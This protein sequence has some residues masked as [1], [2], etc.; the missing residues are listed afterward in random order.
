M[1]ITNFNVKAVD[2][3]GQNHWVFLKVLTDEGID[4]VGEINPSA[5]RRD[6]LNALKILENRVMGQDP[7]QIEYLIMKLQPTLKGRAT[8]HALSAFEQCLWD[9]LG[10]CLNTPIYT[11]LGGKFR[12]SIPVYANITRAAKQGTAED[13]VN[14]ATKAVEAGHWAIKI[15]PF[16]KRFGTGSALIDHGLHCVHSVQEAI[17]SEIKVLLDCYGLFSLDE[18][19]QI[20]K[21]VSNINLYWL[22]EPLPDSDI[23]GYRQLKKETN[24]RIAGGER[25][26]LINGFWPLLNTNIMDVIMPDVT[27][28]GGISELKKIASIA[29]HRGVLTSPHGPFGPVAIAAHV[30][31]MASHPAFLILEYAWGQVPWR[32]RLIFP[33]EQIDRGHIS[34]SDRPGL[35]VHLDPKIIERQWTAPHFI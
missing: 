27:V 28:A 5:P 30:Q 31:I 29:S 9:I 17:G 34:V 13:F 3:N 35:G 6:V 15:A 4:G 2:V 18:A 20:I 24:L 14:Q 11:L 26:M 25:A 21:S 10:K 1:Q 22:E 12:D 16:D 7:R 8:I 19:R 32:E 23:D 33:Q